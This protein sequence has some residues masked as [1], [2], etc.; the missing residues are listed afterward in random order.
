MSELAKLD[1][2][3]KNVSSWLNNCHYG[4]AENFDP[5]DVG[6]LFSRYKSICDDLRSKY[7][8][9]FAD[10]PV[11]EVKSS[12]TSDFEGR[13]YLKRSQLEVLL[14]DIEYCFN[15]QS[16]LETI[17]VPSMKVTREGIFFAGQYFDAILRVEEILSNAEREI[18]IIDGYINRKVLNMLTT[19]KSHVE[20]K[21]LTKAD[22][23][24]FPAT[25][26]VAMDFN[27]QYGGL[28]IRTSETFHDRFIFFDD[29]DFYHFGAS[30]KD[31]GNRGFMF[32][33]IEEP[34]I[35]RS[36][37]TK[38]TQEWNKANIEIP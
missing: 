7:P 29:S 22:Q 6:D 20:A 37:Y 10:L 24:D 16:Q 1:A 35:V 3:W 17:D 34:E 36:L 2:L 15:I 21:I 32:S 14:W 8:S 30:I 9:H 38:F 19:K 31:L 4:R 33:R 12:G 25:K 28:S 5:K 27:K 18:V 13:G 26:A 11:R 23:K